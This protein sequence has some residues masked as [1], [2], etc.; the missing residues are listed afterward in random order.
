MC[1]RCGFHCYNISIFFRTIFRP[2]KI[3]KSVHLPFRNTGAWQESLPSLRPNVRERG[4]QPSHELRPEEVA[5]G[6]GMRHLPHACTRSLSEPPS[7]VSSSTN[8]D[9][10]I[11][12]REFHEH[13]CCRHTTS[14]VG[15]L[16]RCAVTR[17]LRG[18]SCTAS[19]PQR[20]QPT[21]CRTLV[22]TTTLPGR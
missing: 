10:P 13:G 16:P 5:G 2:H 9:V 20:A 21:S 15:V 11:L 12:C 1:I 18:A 17:F 14:H 7:R 4:V 8:V 19:A 3:T 22:V 6:V